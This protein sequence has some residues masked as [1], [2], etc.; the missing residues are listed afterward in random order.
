ML[1]TRKKGYAASF[2]PLYNRFLSSQ[3]VPILII[4]NVAELNGFFFIFN[5]MSHL[6]DTF[7]L[8]YFLNQNWSS[9]K[10]IHFGE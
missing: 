7:K 2:I 4:Y 1:K 5:I 6:I 8:S 9:Y 3:I 10:N